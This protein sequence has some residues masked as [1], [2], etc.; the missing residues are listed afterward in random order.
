MEK[1]SEV[2]GIMES[3][4]IQ[5]QVNYETLANLFFYP[6]NEEYKNN[7]KNIHSYLSKDIPE[8]ANAMQPFIDFIEVATIQEM[9][10]LFLRSFDLQAIT[11]L[12]IGFVLFGEDYKRGKLLVHLNKE[13]SE[14]GNICHTELSDHLPN[15]LNLI[16]KMKDIEIRDEI[17]SRLV[18]PAVDK[19]ISEFSFEKIDKKDV[20]YKKHQKVLLE[21]SKQYRTVYQTLLQALFI[22]MKKDFDYVPENY[23]ELIKN[24][25]N[26]DNER[27]SFLTSKRDFAT[28]EVK[29]FVENIETEM[30]TEKQ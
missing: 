22:A 20:V 2:N 29:D 4:K 5:L 21:F 12:D 1:L 8:A 7:I 6:Q 15:V 28:G 25:G 24:A 30:L 17:A 10:E 23:E 18:M 14:A 11:T 19:M 26:S 9:Q 3:S 16:A 13:H 27:P